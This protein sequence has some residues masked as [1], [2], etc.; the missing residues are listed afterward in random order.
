M[1]TYSVI[2]TFK[3]NENVISEKTDS[4]PEVIKHGS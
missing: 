3:K 4:K 1:T 2:H